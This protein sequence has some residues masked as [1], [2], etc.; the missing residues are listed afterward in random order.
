MTTYV[1]PL[2]LSFKISEKSGLDSETILKLI[3][4][5]SLCFH[6][7]MGP[8]QKLKIRSLDAGR[9][10]NFFFVFCDGFW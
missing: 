6:L 2:A 10:L 8:E 9:V 4:F 1:L 5:S 3:N 7:N